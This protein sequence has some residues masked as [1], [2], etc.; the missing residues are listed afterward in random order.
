MAM[1]LSPSYPCPT[2]ALASEVFLCLAHTSSTHPYLATEPV[3]SGMLK[4]MD[5][6]AKNP[7]TTLN[8]LTGLRFVVQ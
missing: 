5:D 3:I 2:K 6:E 8:S 7:D 4:A 1:A